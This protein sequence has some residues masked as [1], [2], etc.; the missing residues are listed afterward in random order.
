ME[1]AFEWLNKIFQYIWQFVPKPYLVIWT[2]RG[3]RYRRG[4]KPVLV[5]P[6]FRWYW[7]L[8]TQVRIHDVVLQAE[9]FHPT[10]YTTRDGKAF[11]IGYSM[12]FTLE[13]PVLADSA[14]DNFLQ[15][16]GELAES[17]LSPIVASHTFAEILSMISKSPKRGSLDAM[18]SRKARKMCLPF[19]V[20]VSY[21][22]CHTFA[23]TR[24]FT[25]QQNQ[26][27]G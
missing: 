23:P 27:E 3:V 5:K 22:R 6:G 26:R 11:A 2:Q 7:P 1:N 17:V 19:G 21:C 15:T 16:I 20:R 14:T 12:V 4:N 13:D 24:V 9:E 10:V 18:L 8:T 25:L